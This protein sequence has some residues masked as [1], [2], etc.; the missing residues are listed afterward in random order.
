V[1]PEGQP[2]RLDRL[3]G[4]EQR[5]GIRRCMPDHAGEERTRPEHRQTR[6]DPDEGRGH[7]PE[8]EEVEHPE[9]QGRGDERTVRPPPPSRCERTHQ[10]APEDELLH[11]AGDKAEQQDHPGHVSRTG[12]HRVAEVVEHA[13]SG[14]Q[15]ERGQP[16]QVR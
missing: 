15:Q 13:L 8:I 4:R 2:D 12:R 11:D 7:Y 10:D 3:P 9:D 1:P 16:V 14:R 6:Q 5:D